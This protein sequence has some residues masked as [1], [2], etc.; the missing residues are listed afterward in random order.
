MSDEMDMTVAG[1]D[2]RWLI[3]Q[4]ESDRNFPII[5]RTRANPAIHE[6]A[7]ANRITAVICDVDNQL[8]NGQGMPQCMDA[9]YDFEDRLVALVGNSSHQAFHTASITGDARR[10]IYF[11][12]SPD[13]DL[14]ALVAS[15]PIDVARAWA[16]KDLDFAGYDNLVWPTTLDVQINQD[17]SVIAS[18]QSHG[19]NGAVPR[20]VDFF[21]YGTR[22]SLED[23]AARLSGAGMVIDHWLN[24]EGTGLAMSRTS[25]ITHDEFYVLT[26][27]IV[28]AAQA[29]GVDYDGW[30]SPIATEP[31]AEQPQSGFM[32]K[33]FGKS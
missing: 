7:G 16:A 28:D 4:R 24:D 11:V 1:E 17:H 23:V 10:V 13:L 14:E 2:D 32:K 29:A 18:L 30:G 22:T 6:L 5:I 21:F 27:A 25:P 12:H 33:L 8:V 9:L 15:I 31:V 19:D 3:L 20:K 26:P